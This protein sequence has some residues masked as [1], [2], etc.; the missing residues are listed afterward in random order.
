MQLVDFVGSANI[1]NANN[2]IVGIFP[3]HCLK[4]CLDVDYIKLNVIFWEISFP[5]IYDTML[6]DFKMSVE[7]YNT[8]EFIL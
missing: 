8:M 7:F 2:R 4:N 3:L 5:M 6:R 1:P